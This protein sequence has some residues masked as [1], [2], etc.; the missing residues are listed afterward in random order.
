MTEEAKHVSPDAAEEAVRSAA[1]IVRAIAQAN[2]AEFT[3]S[4]GKS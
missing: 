4:F 1:D 3:D 2:P